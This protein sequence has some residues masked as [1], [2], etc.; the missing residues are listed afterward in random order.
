[1]KKIL[2]IILVCVGLDLSAQNGMLP[3]Y[4]MHRVVIIPADTNQVIT[5]Y[6]CNTTYNCAT[7]YSCTIIAELEEKYYKHEEI[8]EA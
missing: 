4:F 7:T 8:L 1:M 5:T 6:D 2:I 3:I